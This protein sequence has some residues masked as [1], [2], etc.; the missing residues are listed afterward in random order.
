MSSNE[1]NA[2]LSHTLESLSASNIDLNE[3]A[4]LEQTGESLSLDNVEAPTVMGKEA[5]SKS[6]PDA[7][8]VAELTARLQKLTACNEHLKSNL[9][10]STPI[11]ADQ[12]EQVENRMR[13]I[14]KYLKVLLHRIQQIETRG[15]PSE[16]ERERH[17]KQKVQ[18][19]H[20]RHL[21]QT[22]LDQLVQ[23]ESGSGTAE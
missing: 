7:E 17:L 19:E 6:T 21:L 14:W 9:E 4:D 15:L 20:I 3:I 8:R 13:N 11:T 1:S 12:F 16:E 22:T 2:T 18:N 5:T 10:S 23:P